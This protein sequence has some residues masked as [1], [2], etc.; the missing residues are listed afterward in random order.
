MKELTEYIVKALVDKP[1]MVKVSEVASERS[2]VIEVNVAEEDVG[3]V[4]GKQGRTISAIRVVLNAAAAKLK[5][6]VVLELID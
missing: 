4:I 3:R 6:R 2:I 5:K 1:E